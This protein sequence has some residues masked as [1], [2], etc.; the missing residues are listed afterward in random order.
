MRTESYL[1]GVRFPEGK[2]AVGVVDQGGNTTVRVVLCVFG[3]VTRTKRG[4]GGGKDDCERSGQQGPRYRNK[5]KGGM[6][7]LV[8]ALL[9]VEE[10]DV[11]I[12]Q[13]ELL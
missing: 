2:V 13:T 7:S 8:L 10:L 3:L 1:H 4:G 12:G 5:P 9:E 6:Y 11:D